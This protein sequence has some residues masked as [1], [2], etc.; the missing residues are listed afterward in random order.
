MRSFARGILVVFI[1]GAVSCREPKWAPS[2][3]PSAVPK[4]AIWAGG[5]DGGVYIRC[6]VDESSNSD[7]CTTWNDY[8]GT[9]IDQGRF[10]LLKEGRAARKS[11]LVYTWADGAGRIGLKDGRILNRIGQQ[12]GK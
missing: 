11:E 1:L 4:D 5:Q 6:E 3:R 8:S 12:D 9:I 10:Q 7:V 2:K